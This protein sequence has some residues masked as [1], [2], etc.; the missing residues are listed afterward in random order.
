MGCFSDHYFVSSFSCKFK[1]PFWHKQAP[2]EKKILFKIQVKLNYFCRD[3]NIYSFEGD[4]DF[5]ITFLSL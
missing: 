2:V 4:G 5:F 1:I 3:L